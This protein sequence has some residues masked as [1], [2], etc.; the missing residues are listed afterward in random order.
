MLDRVKKRVE[1]LF[2]CALNIYCIKC[3]GISSGG[4]SSSDG[5]GLRLETEDVRCDL[6][7]DVRVGF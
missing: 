5:L 3:E 2:R 6:G 4:W 7:E 1:R